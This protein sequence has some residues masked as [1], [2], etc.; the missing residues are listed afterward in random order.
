M[1]RGNSAAN[2]LNGLAGADYMRGM[3]GNDTYVV[4]NAGDVVDESVMGSSGTDL[5]RSSV[6]INL[7]DPTHFKGFIEHVTLLGSAAIHA[8]GNG[9]N[10]TLTGNGAANFLVG[11]AGS[12]TLTGGAG[13]DHFVFDTALG[14]HQHR[15]H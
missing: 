10:N 14:A 6:T 15:H 3:G 9:L 5:V 1:I 2:T 8:T 13:F 4:D 7:S 12:D 11:R